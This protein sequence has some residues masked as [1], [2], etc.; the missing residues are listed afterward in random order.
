MNDL[1]KNFLLGTHDCS[2]ERAKS[3]TEFKRSIERG[4]VLLRFT[5][6][7]GG[8]ELS[9]RLNQSQSS[10]EEAHADEGRGT[11]HLVGALVLDYNELEMSAAID[12]STLRGQASF[13]L[14]RDE[15]AWRASRIAGDPMS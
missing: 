14:L 9:V 11:A 3:L 15:K 4:Y 5:D 12:L 13:K 8:T 6:T 10:I 1:V 7:R 2:A